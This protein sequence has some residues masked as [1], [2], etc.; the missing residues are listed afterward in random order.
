MMRENLISA[1]AAMDGMPARQW[2]IDWLHRHEW[3]V[4]SLS[5]RLGLSVCTICNAMRAMDIPTLDEYRAV[6]YRGRWDTVSGHAARHRVNRSTAIR[7]F[8]AGCPLHLVFQPT[9]RPPRSAPV[10]D[11]IR[12]DRDLIRLLLDNPHHNLE[13]L[14][15][16][17][18]Q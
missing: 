11:A 3:D 1:M 14:Q 5:R 8:N 15:P 7:R 4:A 10:Q 17:L 18:P 12:R 16:Y 6:F 13:T 2:L 9:G